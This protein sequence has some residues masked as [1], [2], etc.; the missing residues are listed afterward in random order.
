MG[1]QTSSPK[2]NL[3]HHRHF[4]SDQLSLYSLFQQCGHQSDHWRD[5][6]F[7]EKF[8]LTSIPRKY[9]RSLH[10]GDLLYLPQLDLFS[11]TGV[12]NDLTIGDT[13]CL[14]PPDYQEH[15]HSETSVKS[16]WK[17]NE[18][19]SSFTNCCSHWF[20]AAFLHAYAVSDRPHSL[21]LLEILSKPI[22]FFSSC[23]KIFSGDKFH[24]QNIITSLDWTSGRN[25]SGSSVLSV[26]VFQ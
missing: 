25:G 21:C 5:I 20:S 17:A 8:R 13:R 16:T 2:G 22:M 14:W 1:D 9:L 4:S 15:S 6:L 23:W 18:S 3:Q 10:Q 12:I 24:Y 19:R 11:N 26:T 7:V